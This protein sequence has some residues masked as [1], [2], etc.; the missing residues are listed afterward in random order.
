MTRYAIA[1]LPLKAGYS[2][3]YLCHNYSFSTYSD[4]AT[5]FHT[6]EDAI[7]KRDELRK[8]PGLSAEGIAAIVVTTL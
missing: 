3:V 6:W 1:M 8:E 7:A 4:H 5:R 2:T